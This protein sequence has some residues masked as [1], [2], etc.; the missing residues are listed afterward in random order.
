MLGSLHAQ[1]GPVP[2][3]VP[4]ASAAAIPA[5][6]GSLILGE[7]FTRGLLVGGAL[8]VLSVGP[9]AHSYRIS[10]LNRQII[11]LS[12]FRYHF[13]ILGVGPT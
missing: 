2:Q 13:C 3:K 10:H 5:F 6:L 12:I 11:L 7:S 4:L 1:S 8:I 9:P